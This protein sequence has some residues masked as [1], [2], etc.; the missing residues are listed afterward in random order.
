MY[1]LLPC[2]I[3]WHKVFIYMITF[4]II[5]SRWCIVEMACKFWILKHVLEK[6]ARILIPNSVLG[7]HPRWSVFRLHSI[8]RESDASPGNAPNRHWINRFAKIQ[9]TCKR[10][11]IIVWSKTSCPKL[12]QNVKISSWHFAALVSKFGS[13]EGKMAIVGCP[14][15]SVLDVDGWLY[16]IQIQW[17]TI[18]IAW[19]T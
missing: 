19:F 6:H 9:M 12:R 16:R 4:G 8:V 1:S 7:L 18:G 10:W 15:V 17:T 13:L 14:I 2:P 11:C 5:S 3:T